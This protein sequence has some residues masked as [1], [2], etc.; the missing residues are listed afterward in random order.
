MAVTVASVVRA[1]DFTYVT[2]NGAI[3]ITAYIG[4]GSNVTIP[5]TTTDLPVTRIGDSAFWDRTGVNNITIPG[6][7]TNIGRFAFWNC[8]GLDRIT[9]PDSVSAIG[10][11]AFAGC[12]FTRLIIPES[13]TGISDRLLLGCSALTNVTIGS[14]DDGQ[15]NHEAGRETPWLGSRLEKQSGIKVLITRLESDCDPGGACVPLGLA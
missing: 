9:M 8:R 11:G 4:T 10:E 14:A 3:T 13:V 1:G 15:G 5:P 2:N 7:V 6:T 12:S